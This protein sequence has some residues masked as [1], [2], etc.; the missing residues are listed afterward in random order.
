MIE[1][2]K[3]QWFVVLIAVIFIGFAVYCIYD[4]NK[5][6][7]PGKSVDGKDVVATIKGDKGAVTADD[8]FKD[9]YN[10]TG[11]NALALQ[12]QIAVI[13]QSV[14]E[15]DA[16][17]TS[18]TNYKANFLTNAEQQMSSYGATDL[19][20]FINQQI[21]QLGYSYDTLDDYCMLMVKMNK[22]QNDYIEKHLDELFTTVYD[23]K[24][25][26]T[27]SHILV[28]MT[29]ANNPTEEEAKKVK[30]IEDALAKGDSFASVAKKYSDDSAEQSGYLGYMDADTQFVESFKTAATSLKKGEV[31]PW[32][33]ESNTNYNGWHM[34]KVEETDKA[35]LM[36]DKDI[37]DALYA[38]CATAKPEMSYTF[39]W[40]A[41]KKLDIKY[42]SDDTKKQIMD[43]FGVSE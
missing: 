36:K 11:Q 23:T 19:K 39:I 14:K 29:D 3:K 18:A 15:T 22:M 38:A 17:K 16:I 2:L 32:V 35:A 7:V 1:I 20:S 31:S 24:S 33:K 43:T 27:V 9:L 25:P 5:D 6:K 40:E 42:A 21:A 10:R 37:K 12:F 34:I 28:K 13:D 26:R 4:S 8:L 30:Q 41:S